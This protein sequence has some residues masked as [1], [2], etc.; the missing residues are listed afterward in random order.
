M[1]GLMTEAV[2]HPG[3]E[4][5]ASTKH[6]MWMLT[7]C[8]QWGS[9]GMDAGAQLVSSLFTP[10]PQ[11]TRWG[12]THSLL[13]HSQLKTH[14]KI[15][16]RCFH[17]Y[18]KSQQMTKEAFTINELKRKLN[19]TRRKENKCLMNMHG[20][21]CKRD[22]SLKREKEGDGCRRIKQTIHFLGM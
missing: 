18:S 14:R 8:P 22:K 13:S 9:R 15:R 16:P 5:M 19:S 17:V 4:G 21:N 2:V 10:G 11:P 3:G 6:V 12:H 7:L 1:F 20:G